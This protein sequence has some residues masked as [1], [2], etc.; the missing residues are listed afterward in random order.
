MNWFHYCYLFYYY[1]AF[2]SPI[3][4][5][6]HVVKSIIYFFQRVWSQKFTSC[7]AQYLDQQLLELLDSTVPRESTVA[8]S[9]R[10]PMAVSYDCSNK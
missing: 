2:R 4:A 9:T 3:L 7:L 6:K 10:L 8:I 1:D 5:I